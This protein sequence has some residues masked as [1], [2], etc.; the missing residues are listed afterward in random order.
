MFP[1]LESSDLLNYFFFK[2]VCI[3]VITLHCRVLW[4][5]YIL[6]CIIILYTLYILYVY[7]YNIIHIIITLY[8]LLYWIIYHPKKNLHFM[9][10]VST[11]WTHD[12]HWSLHCL[13]SFAS[14]GIL[15][16][17][18]AFSDWL[19][20]LSNMPWKVLCVFSWPDSSFIFS[21]E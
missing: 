15:E 18:V 4:V 7:I 13:H 9:Y 21:A 3:K 5:L 16:F 19:L 2:F 14:S 11:Q 1:F 12:N 8:I 20:S 17:C 6:L 10:S